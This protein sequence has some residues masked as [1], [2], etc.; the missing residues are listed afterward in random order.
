VTSKAPSESRAI[1]AAAC[2]SSYSSVPTAIGS[3]GA[4]TL[5]RADKR[6]SSLAGS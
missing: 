5:E 1:E 2:S 4:A 3:V 6:E